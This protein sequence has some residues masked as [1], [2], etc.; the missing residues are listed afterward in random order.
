MYSH[1]PKKKGLWSSYSWIPKNIC[2]WDGFH[3]IIITKKKR[4]DIRNQLRE[5]RMNSRLLK[6]Q[7]KLSHSYK[8]F[9]Q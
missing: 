4:L 7:F 1:E 5:N 9:A 6:L 3:E 2:K 8:I